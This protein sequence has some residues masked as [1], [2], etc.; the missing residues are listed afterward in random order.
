MFGAPHPRA[1][2]HA[3]FSKACGTLA[4]I[5]HILEHKASLNTFKIIEIIPVVFSDHDAMELEIS[6][7]RKPG[8]FTNLWKLNITHL[9]NHGVKEKKSEKKIKIS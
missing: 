9:N 8:R 4:W 6:N 2:E 5:A 3:D 1:T 7:R